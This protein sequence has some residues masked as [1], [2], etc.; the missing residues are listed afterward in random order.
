MSVVQRNR[1]RVLYYEKFV[2][3]DPPAIVIP[4]WFRLE[5]KIHT[6][7]APWSANFIMFSY[8]AMKI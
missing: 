7:I 6:Q 8:A 2:P 4:E 3:A 1:K 5:Y